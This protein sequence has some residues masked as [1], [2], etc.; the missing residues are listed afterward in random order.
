MAETLSAIVSTGRS[1]RTHPAL[2]VGLAGDAP[3][4][5][6][7]RYSLA[8]LDRVELGRGDMRRATRA[9]TSGAEVLALALADP[10][11]SGQHARI[12]RI[13]SAWVVEDLGS[14]NGTW[15][16]TQ[17][18]TRHSLADGD[19]LVVGHTVLVYRTA[20]GEASDVEELPAAVHGFA[21]MSPTLASRFAELA[22]AALTDVAIQ[23]TGESGTGKELVAR[24]VH[25]LSKRSGRFVAVNCGALPANLIEAEMFGHR[26]GAFTGA[27]DERLGLIRSA[28][29]G[30]LFLDEIGEL[31]A[32]AQ[33]ALLRVLQEHEVQ[34]IGADRPVKVDLRVVTATHR[35]LDTDVDAGRFRADLRSR[36]L[37]VTIEL[38]ALRA[39]R[40]DLGH[41]ISALVVK[42]APDRKIAFTA[43]AVAALYTHSWPLNIRELERSLGAA[44][45]VANDRIELPHLPLNVRT[46]TPA[47]APPAV[48]AVP[49]NDEGLRD[50]LVGSIARHD[51]NLAAVAR[52]LGKD[53][54]QIRRWMKKF[55]LARADD[56]GR[57]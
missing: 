30:T 35:D 29:G 2:Y 10:R 24:A 53:R 4:Q 38:P 5:P 39:R 13:G 37:G 20:G 46:P 57:E 19:A 47:P 16:G 22:K 36:L 12:S 31:P 56:A 14:K 48:V 43:D 23:I 26:K 11:M 55:G 45:A 50:M 33:A 41:L 18:I 21:T 32:A 1:G 17:R 8:G 6:P 54:T 15:L 51:G 27:G 34:P 7:A 52:E 25:Q 44:L 3:R 42:L 40:E 28:D 9:T 49:D